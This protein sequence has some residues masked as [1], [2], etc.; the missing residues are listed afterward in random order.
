MK[1]IPLFLTLCISPLT[2]SIASETSCSACKNFTLSHSS[3]SDLN[4]T[5]PNATENAALQKEQERT[6]K[7]IYSQLKEQNFASENVD[8]LAH[9]GTTYNIPVRLV[10]FY[11]RTGAEFYSHDSQ[12]CLIDHEQKLVYVKLDN[13]SLAE[14]GEIIDDPFLALRTKSGG[15][16]SKMDVKASWENLAHFKALA[17]ISY[18]SIE[19][20]NTFTEIQSSTL[21]SKSANTQQRIPAAITVTNQQNH[22]SYTT[23]SFKLKSSRNCEQ[24]WW[25]IAS[26]P[27]FS[28][29]IPNFEGMQDFEDTISLDNLTD[30][31]FSN[32]ADYFFRIKAKHDGVWSDWSAPY[33]FHITKPETVKNVSFERIGN[34][35]YALSWI[36][37]DQG[38]VR[39]H[40]FASNARDFI[41]SIYYDKQIEMLSSDEMAYKPN[42]NLINT[43]SENRILIDGK[44]AYY[45]IIA[46]QEGHYSVPSS[47]IYVYDKGLSHTRTIL[48]MRSGGDTKAQRTSFPSSYIGFHFNDPILQSISGA[49]NDTVLTAPETITDLIGYPINPYVDYK[50]WAA[51]V[52]HFLPENHPIK[53]T[54]DRIFSERVTLT[55]STLSKAGFTTPQPRRASKTIVSKHPKLSG[56]FVKCFTDEQKGVDDW[57]KLK[58]RI[59]GVE[60]IKKAIKRNHYESIFK[61]PQKWIYPLPAEPSPPKN[62]SR[63]NF[64][65]IAEDVNIFVK[66]ENYAAWRGPLMTRK[67]VEAIFTMLNEEGLCDSVYAFNIPFTRD[68]KKLAFID[69]EQ[70]NCWPVNFKRVR[71]YFS[72]LMAKYW[73]QLIKTR[74]HKKGPTKN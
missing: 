46:E 26:D 28:F 29:I 57:K 65:L 35:N 19:S 64:I 6:I 3:S 22:F 42:D 9:F 71:E 12:W 34:N 15:V 25:Q 54:L 20:L 10:P 52:P 11:D 36:G 30:T 24:I 56:Y 21:L 16:Q 68:D 59:D 13:Q 7:L 44:Y 58:R 14:H 27:K 43:T 48:Q 5:I 39:Y 61:V 50:K 47:L 49:D 18:S 32:N 51:M 74:D 45:R 72:P 55:T 53:A 4:E 69:T 23:P 2:L 66:E 31:F 38:N 37:S 62:S 41:P 60:A 33:A 40:V 70:W 67:K 8:L 1:K 63:K 73:D 17:P